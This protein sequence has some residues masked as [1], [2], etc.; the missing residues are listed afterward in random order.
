MEDGDSLRSS[1][2]T[3]IVVNT[4]FFSLYA[5]LNIIADRVTYGASTEILPGITVGHICKK[6]ICTRRNGKSAN[7]SSL[8]RVKVS[9]RV[10]E[11]TMTTRLILQKL[12]PCT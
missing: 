8:I 4:V 3:V 6:H 12:V 5:F 7:P 11:E 10:S 2:G 9:A 1:G